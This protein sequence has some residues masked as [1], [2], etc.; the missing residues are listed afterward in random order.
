[1]S[2]P[3]R[4][5]IQKQPPQEKN[6]SMSEKIRTTLILNENVDIARRGVCRQGT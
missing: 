2:T 3:K 6:H 5:I 1:M 4:A